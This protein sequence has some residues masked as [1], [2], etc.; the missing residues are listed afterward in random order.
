MRYISVKNISFQ[1]ESEQVI[2]GITYHIDSG[3]L[4]TMTGE[5]GAAKSTLINATLG[6]LQ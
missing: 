1:Y 2:E 6:S 5:N 4:V 3:E